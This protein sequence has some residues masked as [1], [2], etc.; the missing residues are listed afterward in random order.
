MRIM[1]RRSRVR[2]EEDRHYQCTPT[3]CDASK[4][5]RRLAAGR[6]T[7]QCVPRRTIWVRYM[8]EGK[9]RSEGYATQQEAEQRRD[10][11]VGMIAEAKD[12]RRPAPPPKAPLFRDLLNPALVT[13]RGT[14]T[15]RPSTLENHESFAQKHVLPFF[16]MMPVDADHFDRSAIRKFITHLRGGSGT[17]RILSDASIKSGL[18]TLS[19]I[20][21]FAVEEK[22][23]LQNP[24]RGGGALWRAEQPT[25]DIDP[26]TPEELRAII[27]SAYSVDHD[28]GCLVQ[29]VSQCGLRPG[30][31][32]ALRRCDLDLKTAE[33]HVK[34]TFSRGRM[35]KPKTTS[36]TR[37]VSLVDHVLVDEALSRSALAKIKAMK[38]TNMDP[39]ARLWPLSAVAYWPRRWKQALTKAQVRYRKPHAMR[40]S[41]ASILL[42]RGENLLEVQEAGGWRSATVLFSTYARWIKLAKKSAGARSGASSRVSLRRV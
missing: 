33:V 34:G 15:L 26:F 14:R 17:S 31:G 40:H 5:R 27:A 35:G 12:P 8:A 30:E 38:L 19:I 32:L 29:V 4:L 11:I 21:D 36:S 9:R 2:I 6:K 20:L 1:S 3:K 28:F 13:H 7:G 25:E 10:V 22:H 41:F 18:P 24:L 23:L 39:E 37:V 16:G 42:S